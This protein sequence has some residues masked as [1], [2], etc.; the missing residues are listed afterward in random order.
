MSA[1]IEGFTFL[2]WRR[3]ALHLLALSAFSL[4]GIFAAQ[5]QQFSADIVVRH[6]RVS[7][8]A[9]RLSV[10]DGKV[11]IETAEHADGFF[12]VDPAKP[13]ATFVRPGTR[14]FMDAGQSTR[15]TRVFVPVDPDA[16]CR[17]WQ[18]MAQLAGVAGEGAWRCERTG[19]ETIEGR[20]AVVFKVISGA[21]QESVG[22][23]DRELKFPLRIKTEDGALLALTAIKD[24]PQPTASFEIPA[25]FRKFSL[26]ALMERIKQSDVWV[27]QPGE[28]PSP[29]VK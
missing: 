20:S 11:R 2:R 18:A 17:Q 23:I 7:S 21:G 29:P 12:L 13:S 8:A 16:P 14:V 22:W 4:F 19:E 15:L 26:D 25:S 9:G 6:E 27:A 24:E 1:M 28:Q 3:A 5:A 10:R